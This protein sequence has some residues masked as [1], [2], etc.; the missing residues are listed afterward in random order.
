MSSLIDE[1]ELINFFLMKLI[2]NGVPATFTIITILFAA[3]AFKG[4]STRDDALVGQVNPAVS[5]LYEDLY[6][7]TTDKKPSSIFSGFGRRNNRS[8]SQ[9]QILSRNA[10]IPA[11]QYISVKSLNEKY[12]SYEYNMVQATQS[13]AAAAAALRS[14]NFNRAF[15]GIDLF[16]WCRRTQATR[17]I[18]THPG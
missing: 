1:K 6:G 15:A 14:K 3:K 2:E 7:G 13:K 17:K 5:E 4:K 8:A 9:D 11:K 12:D 10:G 16:I 18:E